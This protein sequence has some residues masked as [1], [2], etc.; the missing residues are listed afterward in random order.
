M[1]L[2]LFCLIFG[3]GMLYLFYQAVMSANSAFLN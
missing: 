3:S 2:T 1:R